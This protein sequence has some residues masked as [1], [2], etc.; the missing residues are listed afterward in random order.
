MKL[1]PDKKLPDGVPEGN[2]A[3]LVVLQPP[4]SIAN[5][6]TYLKHYEIDDADKFMVTAGGLKK[7][8]R[9]STL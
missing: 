8:P 7:P 6:T 2:P 3:A 5:L 9:L 1:T 4:Q